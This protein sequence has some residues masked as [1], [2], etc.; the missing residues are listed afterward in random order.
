M[1]ANAYVYQSRYSVMDTRGSSFWPGSQKKR[2]VIH[3]E[4]LEGNFCY[5]CNI[6][7]REAPEMAH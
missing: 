7:Q 4:Y 2:L 6:L 5:Q 3:R 1:F